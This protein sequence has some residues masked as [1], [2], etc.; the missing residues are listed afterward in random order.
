MIFIVNV[1][2]KDPLATADT[3]LLVYK[4]PEPAVYGTNV[5]LPSEE[6]YTQE[7]YPPHV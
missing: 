3:L 4:I 6:S 7:M 5:V 1:P 2:T